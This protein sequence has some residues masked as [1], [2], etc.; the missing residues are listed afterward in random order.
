[1]IKSKTGNVDKP[2][3][4]ARSLE[5]EIKMRIASDIEKEH[6]DFLS[7]IAANLKTLK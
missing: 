5:E 7:D 2:I 6:F 3:Y 1:M 4:T